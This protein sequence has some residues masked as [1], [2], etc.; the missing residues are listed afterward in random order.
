MKGVSRNLNVKAMPEKFHQLSYV[1]A[2]NA[3]GT[4]FL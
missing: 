4:N 3:Y 1:E 2:T